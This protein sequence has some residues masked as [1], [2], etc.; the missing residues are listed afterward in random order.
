MNEVN[1]AGETAVMKAAE[2][3]NSCCLQLL[4]DARADVNAQ[5]CNGVTAF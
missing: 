2:A 5:D 4:V 3:R 1:A